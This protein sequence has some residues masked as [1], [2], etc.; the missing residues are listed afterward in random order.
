[1]S[2]FYFAVI[3]NINDN[4]RGISG[5]TELFLNGVCIFYLTIYFTIRRHFVIMLVWLLTII[6]YTVITDCMVVTKR[7]HM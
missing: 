7:R 1:M 2:N 5:Q 4:T 3:I 6:H